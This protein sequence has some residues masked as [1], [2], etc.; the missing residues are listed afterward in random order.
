MKN[1]GYCGRENEWNALTCVECGT[2]V[3]LKS[4]EVPEGEAISNRTKWGL[5]FAAWGVT[6]LAL[7]WKE[8]YRLISAPVFPVGLVACLSEGAAVGLM[9]ILSG[10]PAIILGWPIYV[11]VTI[12]ISKAK[13]IRSFTLIF[14]VLCILLALNVSGCEKLAVAM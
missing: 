10:L 1:C 6:T 4:E 5:Y 9:M 14:V 3:E 12:A 7:C 11:V 2:V 8:P 13:G